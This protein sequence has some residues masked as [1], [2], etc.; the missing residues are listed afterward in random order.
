MQTTTTHTHCTL[1][2]FSA[3]L[4]PAREPRAWGR[5]PDPVIR[6][7]G[8]IFD[9]YRERTRFRL[10]CAWLGTPEGTDYDPFSLR[11]V[12]R[13]WHRAMKDPP[14]ATVEIPQRQIST[15]GT[16]YAPGRTALRGTLFAA[17]ALS[18]SDY[19]D[20]YDY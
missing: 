11:H 9:M 18:M 16:D 12:L 2:A 10:E 19:G 6:H 5:D 13:V 7:A 17:L 1:T 3:S 14:P 20:A 8:D 4:Y 15:A